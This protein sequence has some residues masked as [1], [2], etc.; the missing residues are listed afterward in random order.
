MYKRQLSQMRRQAQI[1]IDKADV[2]LLVV[3]VQTGMTDADHEVAQ[4]LLRAGKRIVLCVNKVDRPGDPPSEVYEFY[5]LGV[6]DPYPCLLS[7]SR[8]V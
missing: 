4:M 5:N 1:A 3:D 2:V 8:C 7:T 6:G